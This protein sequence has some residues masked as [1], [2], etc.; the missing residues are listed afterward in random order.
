[1]NTS[2]RICLVKLSRKVAHF[3]F[4]VKS[5][6][7]KSK[8]KCFHSWSF[9]FH[10]VIAHGPFLLALEQRT[11]LNSVWTCAAVSVLHVSVTLLHPGWRRR[12]Q[13]GVHAHDAFDASGRLPWSLK[14]PSTALLNYVQRGSSRGKF[15]IVLDWGENVN[16]GVLRGFWDGRLHN[17]VSR[18]KIHCFDVHR[19]SVKST[20]DDSNL[21]MAQQ[22]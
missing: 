1:M 8:F 18:T 22:K 5:P 13:R 12:S 19:F 3:H 10:W 4:H 6:S 2:L 17:N 14:S 11:F 21:N 20:S 9:S 16:K 15:S 7:S